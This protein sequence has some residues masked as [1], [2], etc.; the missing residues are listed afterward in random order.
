M[1][2][3]GCDPWARGVRLACMLAL[4]RLTGRRVNANFHLRAEDVIRDRDQVLRALAA[5]GRDEREKAYNPHG[6]IR[7][8]AAN[9][10]LGFEEFTAINKGRACGARSLSP[11]PSS[12]QCSAALPGSRAT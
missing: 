1:G 12:H 7:W 8:S 2:A 11:S 5:A 10:K 4:A 9:D 3:L 6:A